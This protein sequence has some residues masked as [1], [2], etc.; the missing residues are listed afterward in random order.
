MRWH[1]STRFGA[2]IESPQAWRGKWHHCISPRAILATYRREPD[3]RRGPRENMGAGL[4]SDIAR[5]KRCRRAACSCN[6][7]PL[8]ARE[9]A[10][11]R[12]IR[13]P[14][15]QLYREDMNAL[16]L[17]N[18]L[19]DVGPAKRAAFPAAH[20]LSWQSAGSDLFPA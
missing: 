18:S 1:A 7:C 2:R 16:D 13:S 4:H 8:T 14:S 9:P 5:R 15:Q 17:Y 3:I 6:G 12:G 10:S 19:P 20:F 11:H